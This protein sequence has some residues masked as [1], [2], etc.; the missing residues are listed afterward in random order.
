MPTTT[1]VPTPTV[2]RPSGPLARYLLHPGATSARLAHHVAHTAAHIAALAGPPA[3]AAALAA[4]AV[5]AAARAAGR[6]RMTSGARL[7]EVLSPPQVD[8]EGAATLWTN[9]V[10]LLRPAWRRVLFGQPHLGFELVGSDAGLTIS[11]WVPG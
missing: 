4:L 9:L 5:L 1:T 10:A 11:L 3:L 8:P 2:P 6:R 7:V